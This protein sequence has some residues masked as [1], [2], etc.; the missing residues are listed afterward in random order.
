MSSNSETI[1]SANTHPGDSTSIIVS[2]SHFKGEGFK[3]LPKINLQY[4][5]SKN[6]ENYFVVNLYASRSYQFINPYLLSVK[7]SI[8][9]LMTT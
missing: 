4:S 8:L 1:L 6:Y 5:T 3:V 7:G 9:Y 2:G